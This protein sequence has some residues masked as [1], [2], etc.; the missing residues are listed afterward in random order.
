[1]REREKKNTHLP[2]RLGLKESDRSMKYLFIH[3]SI[4]SQSTRNLSTPNTHTQEMHTRR[5]C[6]YTMELIVGD[7]I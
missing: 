1:M 7:P 3:Q 6:K 4:L 5:K 2:L